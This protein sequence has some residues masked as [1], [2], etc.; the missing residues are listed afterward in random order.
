MQIPD[1]SLSDEM[2]AEAVQ[3]SGRGNGEQPEGESALQ[4]L[5]RR[6]Q[7]LSLQLARQYAVTEEDAEDFAQEGLLGVVTAAFSY[8]SHR[9]AGFRTFAA[10]C[11]RSRI[12][13]AVKR[14]ISGVSAR[15]NAVSLDDAETRA[16]ET[17]SDGRRSPE[18]IVLE[19]ERLSE[20]Y[21]WLRTILS[22]QEQ[23][24]FLLSLS[25]CSY[26]EIAQELHISEKSVDNAI[27]RARR[28]L[29]AVRSKTDSRAE[30][31]RTAP[32]HPPQSG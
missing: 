21:G 11:I 4:E 23:E 19:R 8:S 20:L 6:Y 15:M 30:G 3:D 26:A 29:R 2:L 12:R 31:L 14:G 18:Q 10:V 32:K 13:S 16:E 5:I 22:R 1:H 25:D 9:G 17:I 7:G 27:Q 28:K 24:I